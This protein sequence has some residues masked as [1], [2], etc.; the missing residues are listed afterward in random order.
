MDT[1]IAPKYDVEVTTV[2]G[3]AVTTTLETTKLVVVEVE[4]NVDQELT[5]AVLVIV[6]VFV[7]VVN[8]GII[9]VVVDHTVISEVY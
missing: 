3:T 2:V 9:W 7:R 4:V 6:A 5:V 8:C 1:A